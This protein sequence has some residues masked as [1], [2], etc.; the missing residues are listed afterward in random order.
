MTTFGMFT[1]EG[2]VALA[3][4][5]NDALASLPSG[6][7]SVDLYA[8]VLEFIRNRPAFCASHPEHDDTA[9]REAIWS[10]AQSAEPLSVSQASATLTLSATIPVSVLTVGDDAEQALSY[11]D[12][13]HE[14][15]QNAIEEAM[16]E[17]Q[18]RGL[19]DSIGEWS[20][21]EMEIR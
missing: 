19:V 20:G 12:E 11:D 16:E 9:V 17:L 5:L 7:H 14:I 18:R 1:N 2:E 3:S 8:Q 21:L 6:I 10:W 4:L 13:V 15:F